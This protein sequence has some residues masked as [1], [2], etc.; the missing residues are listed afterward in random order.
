MILIWASVTLVAI[1]SWKQAKKLCSEYV[2]TLSTSFVPILEMYKGFIQ[3]CESAHQRSPRW[4]WEVVPTLPW[5]I[6]QWENW[7]ESRMVVKEHLHEICIH[8]KDDLQR[9][10]VKMKRVRKRMWR[11]QRWKSTINRRPSDKKSVQQNRGNCKSELMLFTH[12]FQSISNMWNLFLQTTILLLSWT[13]AKTCWKSTSPKARKAGCLETLRKVNQCYEL[14][15]TASEPGWI[16][17]AARNVPRAK[18]ELK[19]L[20]SR[21]VSNL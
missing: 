17:S 3:S 16:G 2:R 14:M 20:G 7:F 13:R 18:T 12:L 11:E 8:M 4:Q 10:N 19:E 15:M 6:T 21:Q 1:G 9:Q 5:R